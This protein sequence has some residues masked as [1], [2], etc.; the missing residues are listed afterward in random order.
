MKALILAAGR[1][2]RISRYLS[3]RPKCTVDIGGISLIE[4][5]IE[6]L[7]SMGIKDIAIIVGYNQNEIRKTLKDYNV[8]FYYNPFYDVTNSVASAWFAKDFIEENDDI[9]IMNGDVYAEKA[10]LEDVIKETLS[11]VL[12]A[13]NTRKEEADYKFLY[14]NNILKKYGK[15]LEGSDIT[16]EYVGI[17]KINK[18]F[19][20]EFKESLEFMIENQN[21]SLWWENALYRLSKKHNIYVKDVDGKFWAE[22]DYIEDYERILKFRNYDLEFNLNVLKH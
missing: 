22:V 3:G 7:D 2:T 18:D 8:K 14:E 21:H 15:E 4:N 5:T 12:F 20:N 11:P 10:L 16:G 19:I 1:G 9:I 13:D 17:A 6:K